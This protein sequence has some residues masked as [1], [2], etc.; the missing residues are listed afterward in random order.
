MNMKLKTYLSTFPSLSRV[1]FSWWNVCKGSGAYN[2]AKK[3][4][5]FGSHIHDVDAVPLE[6]FSRVDVIFHGVFI[7]L[8][9]VLAAFFVYQEIYVEV[10]YKDVEWFVP[11]GFYHFV[12]LRVRGREIVSGKEGHELS[13]RLMSYCCRHGDVSYT[14]Y[15]IGGKG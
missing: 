7:V 12:H 8:S 15:Q 9:L 10:R 14:G 5:V 4:N 6:V 2:S 3:I 11:A 13:V 1:F